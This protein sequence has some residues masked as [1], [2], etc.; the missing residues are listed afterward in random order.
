MSKRTKTLIATAVGVLLLCGALLVVML[1]PPV[2]PPTEGT[3]D[4]SEESSAPETT[5]V[6]LDKTKDEKGDAVAVPVTGMIAEVTAE[7]G[8]VTRI[9]L[10]LDKDGVLH[11]PLYADLP[12][13]TVALSNVSQ[14]LSKIRASKLVGEPE[15]PA[16]FGFDKPSIK[17]SVTY[18]D[19]T[20]Y[21]YEIGS[22]TP[23]EQACYFRAV[24]SKEVYVVE[25]AYIAYPGMTPLGYISTT[26]MAAPV[27][28]KDTETVTNTVVL[29]DMALSGSVRKTPFKFQMPALDD[30]EFA[31]FTYKITAPY[32]RGGQTLLSNALVTGTSL[33]AAV[34]A[35]AHPT[36]EE[37]KACGFDDPYS[38]AFLHTAVKRVETVQS[39]EVSGQSTTKQ[40]YY[41]VQEHT[42]TVGSKEEKSGYYFVMVDDIDVIYYVD[43]AAMSSWLTLQYEEMADTLLFSVNISQLS[44]LQISRPGQ[45]D[46]TCTLEHINVDDEENRS[47]NVTCN[48]KAMP[49]SSLEDFRTLYMLAMTLERYSAAPD[50]YS[51]DPA[52]LVMRLRVTLGD[53]TAPSIDASFYKQSGSLYLC[54]VEGGETYSVKMSVVRTFMERA[55]MYKNG[56]PFPSDIV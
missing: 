30:A 10:A 38:V 7:D 49:E 2:A 5:I 27:P 29:R 24:G 12:Y 28:E 23:D 25:S 43:G 45:E 40:T 54:Q 37:K 31:D 35:I 47:F 52:N 42:I 13:N 16:D 41:N 21:A 9:E 56:Q 55:D 11:C 19:G 18:H 17:V 3:S 22:A 53:E 14:T 46:V 48:G 39:S 51:T 33:S 6:L 20:E 32:V 15:N 1:L 4:S 36:A 8:E 26:L 50:S 44:Q 34:A